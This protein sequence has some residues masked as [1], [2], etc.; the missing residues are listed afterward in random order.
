MTRQVLS[1]ERKNST[2]LA[3]VDK[4]ALAASKEMFGLLIATKEQS[5]KFD[6]QLQDTIDKVAQRISSAVASL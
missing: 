5:G 4:E 3:A 1:L 2:L 6:G